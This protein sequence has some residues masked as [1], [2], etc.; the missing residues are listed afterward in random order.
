MDEE[1]TETW[2]FDPDDWIWE[3]RYFAECERLGIQPNRC[4]AEDC[5]RA[6]P[7]RKHPDVPD[8]SVP[9]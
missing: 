5:D 2:T 7:C 4:R 8:I 9:D 3:D 6:L 1:N